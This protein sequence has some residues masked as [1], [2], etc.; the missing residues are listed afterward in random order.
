MCKKN[1][2]K[3]PRV[4]DRVGRDDAVEEIRFYIASELVDV[5]LRCHEFSPKTLTRL[6]FDMRSFRAR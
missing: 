1:R 2:N 4:W 6:E 3:G 5:K